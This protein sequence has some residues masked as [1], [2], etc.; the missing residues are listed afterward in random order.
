MSFTMLPSNP[1][2]R[3]EIQFWIFQLIGWSLWISLLVLRDLTFIP[4]EYILERVLV[5]LV[6]ASIGILLTTALRYLYRAVWDFPMIIRLVAVV[7][8]CWVASQAWRPIK[9][10]ITD[11]DFGSTVDLTGYVQ[12]V[13]AGVHDLAADLERALLL[14]QILSSVSA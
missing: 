14:P 13:D 9:W 12:S 8:G 1:F 10:L 3:R 7:F 2:W 11:S 6:D 4:R 5:F